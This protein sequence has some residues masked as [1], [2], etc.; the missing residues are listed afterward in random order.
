MVFSRDIG[1]ISLPLFISPRALVSRVFAWVLQCTT[2]LNI[3]NHL[4]FTSEQKNPYLD[5]N[6]SINFNLTSNGSH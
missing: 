4:F 1:G 6:F 5:S 3:P 2:L